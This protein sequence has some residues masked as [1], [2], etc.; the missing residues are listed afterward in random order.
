MNAPML[1]PPTRSISKPASRSAAI[2][3]MWAKPRAP[4]RTGRHRAHLRRGVVRL[5]RPLQGLRRGRGDGAP[6]ARSRRS[7]TTAARGT[8]SANTRS[9]PCGITD[10][11]AIARDDH[12]TPVRLPR[13]ERRP[14]GIASGCEHDERVLLFGLV[15]SRGAIFAAVLRRQERDASEPRK[16]S[17][18]CTAKATACMR[19]RT[20]R[21]R[22]RSDECSAARALARLELV[23][24]RPGDRDGESGVALEQ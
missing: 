15:E 18:S 11:F 10:R 20:R 13:A 23:C 4:P 6:V 2:A 8:P 9:T 19:R 1:Q 24:Q 21:P 14:L 3:P 7:D 5:G 12:D 22:S 16:A 17:A